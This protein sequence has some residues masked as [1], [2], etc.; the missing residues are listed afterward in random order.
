MNRLIQTPTFSAGPRLKAAALHFGLTMLVALFA[1]A[2]VFL[3]WYPFPYRE[4]AGGREL[5]LL[6]V[7]IDV[8][9]GPL[10]TFA[11]FDQAK[12]WRLLRR[13]LSIIG[14]LQAA[15]LAYGLHT[16]YLAR[17]VYLVHEVDR[18]RVVTAVDVDPADLKNAPAG[19]RRLPMW[20]P[21][22]MATRS[23]RSPDEFLRSVELALKGKDVALRP[24]W[25]QPYE[26][27]REQ[28]IQRAK[29]V[30]YLRQ[31]YPSRQHEIDAWVRQTGKTEDQLR[32][33]PLSARRMDWSALV[34]ANSAM[35]LAF[36]AFDAF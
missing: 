26:L 8:V 2:L 35:P 34:D 17:P 15:A 4:V 3:V 16:V 13:D 5:F 12:G 24:D 7:A 10:L 9:V 28:V 31:R 33:V 27:S 6:I 14:A 22:L 36:A 23:P 32:V 25:W 1:A 21:E 18:L 20:G 19:L 30:S 29:P 11:I